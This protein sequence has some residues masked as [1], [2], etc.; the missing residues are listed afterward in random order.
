[1]ALKHLLCGAYANHSER[2]AVEYLKARLQNHAVSNDWILLTNYA[3]SSSSRYLSDELD[4]VVITSSGVILVE[5]K[6]WDST[7]LKGQRLHLT[8]SEAEKLNEKAKRLKGKLQR[9]CKFNCG[10]VEGKF[11]FTRNEKEKFIDGIS[12]YRIR[13]VDVFGL[14]EW[15]DLLELNARPSLTNEQIAQIATALHPQAA[16]LASDEIQNFDNTFFELKAVT[17]ISTPFRRTY[18]ARRQPGRDRVVLHIYDLTASTEKN[19]LDIARREFQIL[20]RLQTSIWLPNLMDSFQEAK[21]YPGELYFFSYI[22]TESPTLAERTRDENWSIEERVFATFRALQALEEI[23][24]EGMGEGGSP[25]LHRNLTPETI[26]IRSNNEPLLTQLYLAK[27]PGAQTVAAAAPEDFGEMAGYFAPEVQSSGIGASTISSDVFSLSSSLSVIFSEAPAGLRSAETEEI[28]NAL[29]RG[30]NP[31]PTKRPSLNEI[32]HE[33]NDIFAEPELQ[34]LAPPDVQFWDENT[35]VELNKR[36]YKIITKLGAGGFGTTFKVME[37]DPTTLDDISGPYVAKAITN[38]EA[39]IDAANAYAKVRAQTG[40]DH[41]AGVLEVASPWEPNSVTALLKWINGIPLDDLS[42][43]LSIHLDDLGHSEYEETILLWLADM[44]DALSQ[45]HRVGLVHG[46]VSPKNIIVDGTNM[47]LTDFDTAAQQGAQP[48]GMTPLYCSPEIASSLPIEFSDDTYALAAT[49]FYTLFERNPFEYSDGQQKARG[50][51]WEDIE[52]EKW[53]RLRAF[54]GKA[55]SPNRTERFDSAMVA[56]D[57]LAN[58][59]R[60]DSSIEVISSTEATQIR[61]DNVVPWLSQLLQSYPGSPKG[62][63]ETRG[64]DSEFARMTY[65]ETALDEILANDIRQRKVSLVIL[66]GNAGDGKTAFLQNLAKNL[67]LEVGASA[68]RIWDVTLS[69]GLRVYANLDG[70]AAFQGR[71]ANELLDECLAPFETD[72]FPDD[73]VHLLAVNDGKLLEWLDDQ[74]ETVL[75][76]QLYDAL[77]DDGSIELTPRIRFIDLNK[78]SLVGGFRSDSTTISADFVEKLLDKMLGGEPDVWNPCHRC[79]AQPRCHAWAS[80]NSLRDADKG[81]ILRKRIVNALLAVHQRGE[82][83]ITARSLRAALVYIFFGTLECQDLHNNPNLF[84]EM[85]FDRAFDFNSPFRQGDLLTELSRLDPAL[86]S[87]PDIDRFLFKNAELESNQFFTERPSLDSLRR[88]A[89]FEWSD[90]NIEKVGG[91]RTALGLASSQHSDTFLR[92]GVGTGS[93]LRVICSQLC[94]GIARLEDLPDEAF[95]ADAQSIPLKITP[96]TPTETAFW[97]SKPREKFSIRPRELPAVDGIET[98]HTHVVLSY[99]FDNG[100]IEELV[101]GA[102]LFN[103]LMELREGFQV[104]DVRSD[105][106][107]ANLSIFKQRLAQEGDRMLYAWNPA[108][109]KVMKLDVEMIEGVQKIQIR[110]IEYGGPV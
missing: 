62:N 34:P 6:H 57:Y 109:E 93:E 77:G 44:C 21:N 65:V 79:T 88:H 94:E 54:F 92:V 28:L 7:A 105:E 74:D 89:Y 86:E 59:I 26:H 43:V 22:D 10:F 27:L 16:A 83:H 3:N 52:P 107:F 68:E 63:A 64:L 33:I 48:L 49:F 51:N 1:L 98:L 35:I 29:R 67:G 41:L 76:E 5:I 14:T 97:V 60:P 15:K 81:G 39:G 47:T 71:S 73:V 50:L 90:E 80:V 110:P 18:R 70:S 95:E 23:H 99:R 96:R 42:G 85:Y 58:L 69:D 102:E 40:T 19:A 84:P 78:R 87:H 46:D 25:I 45:L 38:E 82:I 72:E 104:S 37:V 108:T 13:G 101:I 66:C 31:D 55:T 91:S 2:H 24:Q 61:T 56:K 12:R 17:R 53:S 32:F 103:L 30:I 20:Q 8:E 4:L 100:H 36:S 11:L 106:I 9:L 75:V